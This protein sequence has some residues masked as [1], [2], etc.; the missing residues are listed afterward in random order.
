MDIN[1][2]GKGF[3]TLLH[4]VS[5]GKGLPCPAECFLPCTSPSAPSLQ[6][7]PCCKAVERSISP[8]SSAPGNRHRVSATWPQCNRREI[9]INCREKGLSEKLLSQAGAPSAAQGTTAFVQKHSLDTSVDTVRQKHTVMWYAVT[10]RVGCDR[11]IWK[12]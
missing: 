12:I 3:K 4:V 5:C 6:Q 9:S 2:C 8:S 11:Y 1:C 10:I 7:F